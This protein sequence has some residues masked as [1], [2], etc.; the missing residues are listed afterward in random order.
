MPRQQS[1]EHPG[2]GGVQQDAEHLGTHGVGG[3]RGAGEA[4][5]SQGRRAEEDEEQHPYDGERAGEVTAWGGGRG[6]A[7]RHGYATD[8]R[9]R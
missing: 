6:R 9:H 7:A 1:A 4:D 2:R 3:D 8:S 5:R